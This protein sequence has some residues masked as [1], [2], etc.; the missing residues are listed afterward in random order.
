MV[1]LIDLQLNNN[2]EPSISSNQ[3]MM[4]L[5]EEYPNPRNL[6]DVFIGSDGSGLGDVSTSG[7]VD[8]NQV[9]ETGGQIIGTIASNRDTSN[10]N[11]RR[12]LRQRCGRRPLLRRNRVD[13][14]ACRE[15]FF[16]EMQG[17]T[18]SESALTPEQLMDILSRRDAQQKPKISALGVFGII[19]GVAAVGTAIYFISKKK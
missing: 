4:P 12:S 16:R 15:K 13:Y 3:R 8:W 2:F 14:D 6:F 17:V 5:M 7:N 19:L 11:V 1:E 10:R 18:D 9:I